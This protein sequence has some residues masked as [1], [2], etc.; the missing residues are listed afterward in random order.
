MEKLTLEEIDEKIANGDLSTE[1]L[2][3]LRKK[4]YRFDDYTINHCDWTLKHTMLA[5]IKEMLAEDR[6]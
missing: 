1:Q 4:I 3:E 6:K 5:C 2:K